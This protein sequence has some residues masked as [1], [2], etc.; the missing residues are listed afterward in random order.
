LIGGLAGAGVSWL[1]NSDERAA[2]AKRDK[3]REDFLNGTSA[4][5]LRRIDGEFDDG[6]DKGPIGGKPT[7]DNIAFAKNVKGIKEYIVHDNEMV[8]NPDQQRQFNAA[9]E[10]KPVGRNDFELVVQNKTTTTNSNGNKITVNDIN[11]K[12]G[13]SVKLDLGNASTDFDLIQK[14]ASNRKFK[15]LMAEIISEELTNNINL[16]EVK[17]TPNI[18]GLPWLSTNTA[19][20]M[21]TSI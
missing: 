17:N 8:V 10:A 5:K 2:K 9:I 13:G 16:K 15:T 20:K 19:S 14:L 21:T 1:S 12:I 18:T 7:S 6:L 4:P 3:E 11:L